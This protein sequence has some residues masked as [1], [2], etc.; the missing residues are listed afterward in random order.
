MKSIISGSGKRIE[1]RWGGVF[2][3]RWSE[4]ASPEKVT[5]EQR[6]TWK[7]EEAM[8][9]PVSRQRKQQMCHFPGTMRMM[10]LSEEGDSS[11]GEVR[12]GAGGRGQGQRAGAGLAQ[13]C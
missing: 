13:S 9:D 8:D 3:R 12:A 7:E 5:C 4:K 1:W 6:P 2:W 10:L 11:K